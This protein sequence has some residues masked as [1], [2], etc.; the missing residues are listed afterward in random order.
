M[1]PAKLTYTT[2]IEREARKTEESQGSRQT[3]D[4]RTS[5]LRRFLQVTGC[6]EQDVV[7]L[8]MRAGFNDASRQFVL[9]LESDGRP[10]RS[11]INTLS[12]LRHW[13][14]RVLDWDTELAAS[15][16]KQAPFTAA[17]M[18]AV[19]SAPIATVARQ[20]GV[21]ENMLRG[22]ARGKLPRKKRCIPSVHRLEVFYG[23][24][25]GALTSLIPNYRKQPVNLPSST[26]ATAYRQRIGRVTRDPYFLY[27]DTTSPLRAQ[28]RAFMLYKTSVRP[29]LLRRTERGA[30][31]VAPIPLHSPERRRWWMNL[32]GKEVPSA[33]FAWN[34]VSSY[35]GWLAL[36]PERG[37]KGMHKDEAETLAWLVVPDY[38]EEFIRWRQQRAGGVTNGS[39]L[40]F[41]AQLASLVR[42]TYGYLTQHGC[43][44]GTLPPTFRGRSWQAM[45]TEQFELLE[46]LQAHLAKER[47]V[48]RDPFEPMK[49]VL[50]QRQPM[51]ALADMIARLRADR[52]VHGGRAEAI[53]S[54]DLVLLKI[55]IC[56]PLRRKNLAQLTW[57]PDNTGQLYQR[58]DRTWWVRIESRLFKN[59]SGAAGSNVFDTPVH[60]SVW[61]DLERYLV[62]FRPRLMR[63]PTDLLLLSACS[64]SQGPHQPWKELSYR[65]FDLTERYLLGCSGV[66][67]HAFRHLVATS[68]LK[69]TGND[70]K[71]AAALLN[72]RMST[73]EKHY[74]HITSGDAAMKMAEALKG[75]MSRL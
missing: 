4:N 67:A 32:D 58:A 7:G 49:D 56:V 75:P 28:W 5:A 23:M 63:E 17:L 66:S 47:A 9:S 64:R 72:D 51:E 44:Q 3:L 52:P 69:A 1:E 2:L 6:T 74:A 50:Q 43:L 40:T 55:L 30:W 26:P 71:T 10:R 13:K 39:L 62:H 24:P 15:T 16:D 53:W 59:A 34:H 54:R 65:V 57:R 48:G 12:A 8:E 61:A 20:A 36:Q 70:F 45:C 38:I 25:R 21:P 37:G 11:V 27:P 33:H 42:P 60:E 35:L 18:S 22:W 41:I 14:S 19:G 29:G 73:V 31:R 46:A 68:V